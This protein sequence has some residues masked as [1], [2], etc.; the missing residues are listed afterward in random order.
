MAEL[1]CLDS[2]K[3]EKD[4][5]VSVVADL[6]DASP[7]ITRFISETLLLLEVLL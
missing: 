2:K 7:P 4:S 6:R 3:Q 5:L 1:F